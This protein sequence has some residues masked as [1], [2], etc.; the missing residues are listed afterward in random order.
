G[1]GGPGS[2]GAPVGRG[3]FLRFFFAFL[4]IGDEA[5]LSSFGVSPASSWA[6]RRSSCALA[7]AARARSS[8]SSSLSFSPPRFL[9]TGCTRIFGS[10]SGSVTFLGGVKSSGSRP[11]FAR[12]ALTRSWYSLWASEPGVGAI[13]I[14]RNC[15]PKVHALVVSQ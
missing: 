12:L 7:R 10:G 3:H 2:V 6:L 1:R 8:F 13:R 9:L 5:G 4:E 11:F 15:W 14:T